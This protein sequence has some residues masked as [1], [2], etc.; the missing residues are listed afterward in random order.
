MNEYHHVCTTDSFKGTHFK[1]T[2][3]RALSTDHGIINCKAVAWGCLQLFKLRQS[4]LRLANVSALLLRS[5]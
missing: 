1:R 3:D 5:N 4:R 2:K